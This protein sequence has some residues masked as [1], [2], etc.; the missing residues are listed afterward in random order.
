MDMAE[1]QLNLNI[2]PC[3]LQVSPAGDAGRVDIHPVLAD[4]E[5]WEDNRQIGKTGAQSVDSICLA[6]AILLRCHVAS[7]TVYFGLYAS[8]TNAALND[9][10]EPLQLAS[11]VKNVSIRQYQTVTGRSSYD[12]LP[13]AQG[14]VPESAMSDVPINTA[15]RLFETSMLNHGF[16]EFV[17]SEPLEEWIDVEVSVKLKDGASMIALKTR[18]ST[19]PFHYGQSIARSLRSIIR[20]STSH[21]EALCSSLQPVSL[22]DKAILRSWNQGDLFSDSTCLHHKVGITIASMADSEAVCAWDGSM[23]YAELD[24]AST[25]V[26][27]RLL[28]LGVQ[29]GDL[30]PL[31]FEKSLYAVIAALGILKSGGAFV[32]LDPNHPTERLEEIMGTIQG[33]LVVTSVRWESKYAA[34]GKKTVV[35][36]SAILDVAKETDTRLDLPPVSPRDPAFVLF[37]SGSTGQP[38]GMVHDHE[39]AVT[40]SIA[41]GQCMGYNARVFQFS[42]FTFDMAVWDMFSTLILGGCVCIPSDEDRMNNLPQTMNRMEVEFAFLTP[43]VASL[44]QPAEILTLKRLACGGEAFRQEIV[45]RWRGRIELINQYGIAESGTIAVRHLDQDGLASRIETVGHTLPTLC[46]VLVDPEDHDRLV[47]IGAIGE[48][49]VTGTTISR[50]YINSEAKNRTSFISNPPWAVALGL[51]DRN[52]YKTGDLLQ[53]NVGT[54]DGQMDF[55]RRK[56][57]QLKYHGQRME[58]GEVEH[59]LNGIPG[60]AVSAVVLPTL[61]CFSGRL[62]A[63]VQMSSS[64][65]QKFNKESL[66]VDHAHSLPIAAVKAHL[67]KTLPGY[68][69]PA[70]CILI[71]NMPFTPSCKVDRKSVRVWLENLQ[72]RP[73]EAIVVVESTDTNEIAESNTVARTLS[74]QIADMV[75]T[76]DACLAK[77]L[78]NQDFLLQDA[79]IDSIQTA[80]LAMFV[81]NTFGVKLPMSVF[82]SSSSTVRDLARIIDKDSL[83][84]EDHTKIVDLLREVELHGRDLL[85]AIDQHSSGY[86]NIFLTGA[87]GYLGTSI[88]EK[89]LKDSDAN[90]T[91]LTRCPSVAEALDQIRQKGTRHGWW[92]DGY[93]SRIDI[94]QGDLTEP[95]LGLSEENLHRFHRTI[96]AIIHNGATVHYSRDYDA[97]KASNLQSTRELLKIAAAT[98]SISAF[99]YVSG[100]RS[101]SAVELS[102]SDDASEAQGDSG[103]A[104][105]K[106]VAEYLVRRFMDHPAFAAKTIKIIRPGYIIGSPRNGIAN[107]TDFI[108]RLV[109]GCIE[110]QSINREDLD[111][112]LFISDVEHV[113]DIVTSTFTKPDPMVIHRVDQ[114]LDGILLSSL[115]DFLRVDCGYYLLPLTHTDWLHSLESSVVDK[116]ESHLLFPLLHTLEKGEGRIGSKHAPSQSVEVSSRIRNAIRTNIQFLISEGFLQPP[117][118]RDPIPLTT[119]DTDDRPSTASASDRTSSLSLTASVTK[120]SVSSSEADGANSSASSIEEEKTSFGKSR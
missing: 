82:L 10:G 4:Y 51:E 44:L 42:A 106:F 62:V 90:V 40:H 22:E 26:A 5:G 98:P 11:G 91:V 94:W 2:D 15:V 96:D 84:S 119:T 100:G 120:S 88:L 48:L 17:S 63:A 37:T 19:I 114:I 86:Y 67:S 13:D 33:G 97:L 73:D 60:V 92:L 118:R 74:L 103:Y 23:T 58:A 30:V 79:G 101:P 117:P 47:P 54:F 41:N 116:G 80:S 57:G 27:N 6:W 111:R 85:D 49:M 93:S 64:A 113:A 52:F 43:S 110:I 66:W 38:K 1:K 81:Q 32:P 21:R 77:Q 83:V 12:V 24:S 78:Q 61:G 70:E 71:G 68:M 95:R 104:S 59:H 45:Q 53:Y 87:S 31:S 76:R 65:A 9:E 107:L 105:S 50:G 109:A 108:W 89:L 7:D 18:T 34:L 35:V 115:W 112:W 99:V 56:D 55:V 75:A 20:E 3:R 8:T 29:V 39:A 46:G 25:Q 16:E 14:A 36:T 102:E 28:L 72:P 69:I